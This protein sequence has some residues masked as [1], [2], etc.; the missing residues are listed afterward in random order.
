MAR[1]E[2]GLQHALER[3]PQLREEFWQNVSVPGEPNNLNQNLEYAGRVADYLEFGE[4]LALRRAASAANRAAATSARKARRRTAKRCATTRISAHVAAWEYPGRRRGAGAPQRA[5]GR[6]STCTRRSG[7]TSRTHETVIANVTAQ[8]LASDR[9]E[10]RGQAGRLPV[11]AACLAGH[12]VPRDAGRGQRGPD[13]KGRGAGRVRLRLPRRHLRHLRLMVN[14]VRARPRSGHDRLPAP[15]AAVQGRR[16]DHHR[17]VAR[18]G[19]PGAQGPGRRSQRLRSHHP[20]RRLHV[21][22]RRLGAGRQRDPGAARTSSD[23]GHGLRR[24][25]RL[26]R[27]RRAVQERLGGAVHV[28]PRSSHLALLPQGQPER[29]R[30]VFGDG[31]PRWTPK[32]S[33]ACSNEG[34]CE[35]VC[36]KE[37]SIRASPG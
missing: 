5:A 4:L 18:A 33:A 26:R 11:D 9:T 8:G 1:N 31:R 22:Q 28:P 15:H 36:P 3:I 24:L 19:V 34:E 35:A 17:A 30:R 27:L 6:S 12:V 25:H 32:A 7:A 29:T 16:H 20:G 13:P 2:A 23:A 21:D 10:C 37:I 14:G